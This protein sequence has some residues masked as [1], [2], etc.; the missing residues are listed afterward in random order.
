MTFGMLHVADTA[1]I[2]SIRCC[3]CRCGQPAVVDLLLL[4]PL[5]LLRYT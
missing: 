5:L 3:C 4:P 2:D 1:A